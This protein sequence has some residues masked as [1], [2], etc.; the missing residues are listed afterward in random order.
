MTFYLIGL[1][2]NEKSITVEA[3]EILKKCKTIYLENYTINFPYSLKKLKKTINKKIT[4]LNREQVESEEFLNQAKKQNL[5][6]LVYGSPLTATTHLSL[7]STCKNKKIP[8]KIFHNSSILTAIS[9]TGLQLYK[10]GKITSLPKWTEKYK[11]DSFINY[12][13]QNQKIH[14]HT[15]VLIDINL[16]LKKAKAQLKESEKNHNIKLNKIILCSAIGT[17]KSKIYY[18]NLNKLPDKIP[19][20]FC[21]IIPSKLHF[22]EK[23]FLAKI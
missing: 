4:E 21:F 23:E 17:N 8:Y 9:E 5:A 3:L 13:K 20:P 16:N 18:N 12:I 6:L 2:L 22:T 10:F 1:G 19:K 14:A 7:I 15:L 11:P